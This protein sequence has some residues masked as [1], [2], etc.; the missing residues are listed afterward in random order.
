MAAQPGVVLLLT[1]QVVHVGI[2]KVLGLGQTEHLLALGISQEFAI[3]VQQFQGIPLFGVVRSGNDDAATGML[4]HHGKFSSGSRGK[5]DVNDIKAHA[6]KR[7]D[8]SVKHHAAR[9]ARVTSNNDDTRL[10][11][12][13]AAHEGS[14]CRSELDDIKRREAITGTAADGTADSRYRFD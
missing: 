7:S 3:V 1:S 4:T 13:V 14:V 2:I 8:N 6:S 12:R 9:Q 11:G 10:D 5:A